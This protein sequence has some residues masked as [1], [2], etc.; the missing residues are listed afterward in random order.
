[1]R[2]TAVAF[3]IVLGIG[4]HAR[5]ATCTPT[6]FIRNSINLTALMIN[7]AGTVT[8]DVDATG[9]NIAVYYGPGSHGKVWDANVHGSNYYGIVN[10]GGNVEIAYD[11]ISDIGEQPLNGTQHGVAVYFAFGSASKGYVFGTRIWNYQKGGIVINGTANA[12]VDV[13]HNTVIGQGA[14][15]YIAQNG[16]QVGYGAKVSPH[17]NFVSG[18]SYSGNNGAA[19][20]GILVVGGDCY[21]GPLT[22]N[23]V[24]DENDLVGNDVGVLFS[25]LDAACLPSSVPTK[26]VANENTITNNLV[27]N[28][29]G[30]SPSQGY[31]A[32]IS[33]QG[34]GDTII[35]N[36]VCGR[37]YTGPTT[38]SAALFPIDV[39]STNNVVVKNNTT[40]KG[41]DPLVDGVATIVRPSVIR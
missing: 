7:P 28:T 38:P 21:S 1:V 8:G 30:N 9:C 31:Q 32:G 22:K 39:T 16:I 18:N 3:A 40:C 12:V 11:T 37:G 35:E 6:G 14:V 4:S 26:D 34:N 29:T 17:D 24:V 13:S 15:N 33:D 27:N 41:P 25:N 19:S 10:N 36:D 5:A 20:G 23:I 2:K